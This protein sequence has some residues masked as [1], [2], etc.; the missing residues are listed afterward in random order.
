MATL[1]IE[2]P[3]IEVEAESGCLVLRADGEVLQRV[4][5][6]MLERV[7][8]VADTPIR[9]SVIRG[10]AAAGVGVFWP[11]S[12]KGAHAM[13]WPADR[14]S[15]A[16]RLGQAKVYLEEATRQKYASLLIRGKLL[17]QLQVIRGLQEQRPDK[18]YELSKARL[19][20]AGSIGRLRRERLAVESLLGVEGAASAA[21]FD[22]IGATLAPSL[23]F[24]GRNRRPPRDPVNAALSLGYTLLYGAALEAILAAGLEPAI[25]FLHE[26]AQGRSA[27]AC[28]LMEPFR[29]VG[30]RQ[31]LRMFHGRQ[32]RGEHFSMNQG[33]CL[34]GKAARRE[35]YGAFEEP[36]AEIRKRLRM[37]CSAFC[38]S[39]PDTRGGERA[40]AE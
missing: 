9:G 12:R 33:A 14:Q 37:T 19:H 15:G 11:A 2:K 24:N 13:S 3:G 17:G 22:A 32:L 39:L 7:V 20:L 16:R 1:Y 35:F 38:R 30:D 27:L 36:M 4:P 5:Y 21:Y 40:E 26:P 34:M 18:R 29:P 31:I 25:G 8:V 28:D 23:G 6:Q 10:L